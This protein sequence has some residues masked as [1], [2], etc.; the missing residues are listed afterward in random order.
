MV[1]LKTPLGSQRASGTLAGALTFRQAHS[2]NVASIKSNPKQ[3]RTLAQR[4]T[5]I[6]MTWLSKQWATL[7]FLERHTWL[8]YAASPLLSP[9][10]A[11]IRYNTKRWITQPGIANYPDEF[12]F[13]PSINYP[14]GE[15]TATMSLYTH[16]SGGGPGL[17]WHKFE[18][19]YNVDCWNLAYHL[20]TPAKPQPVPSNLL[21]VETVDHNGWFEITIPNLPAGAQTLKYSTNSGS[22]LP[23]KYYRTINETV[24]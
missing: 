14:A 20:I 11:Y 8:N 5:R 19:K 4:A 18:G 24:T 1:V 21:H 9:Y 17:I 10:H 6:W 15:D 3:P 12:H 13:A 2:R 16:T 22:G 7:S 23:Y